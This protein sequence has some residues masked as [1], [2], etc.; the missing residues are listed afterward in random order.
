MVPEELYAFVVHGLLP[1]EVRQGSC[2][3]VEK[4]E[5]RLARRGLAR[6][7]AVKDP[8]EEILVADWM[9]STKIDRSSWSSQGKQHTT[10]WSAAAYLL[11]IAPVFGK[12]IDSHVKYFVLD[13]DHKGVSFNDE[14]ESL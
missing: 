14:I 4:H 13:A 11:E 10:K 9:E 3:I 6:L 2:Q 7:E 1:I 5:V 12:G 8:R